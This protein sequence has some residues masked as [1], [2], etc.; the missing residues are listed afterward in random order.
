MREIRQGPGM[1]YIGDSYERAEAWI[2][3]TVEGHV[4]TITRTVVRNG[5]QHQGI[6]SRLVQHV[7]EYCREHEYRIVPVCSFAAAYFEKHPEDRD[8]LAGKTR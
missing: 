7:V 5:L 4:L 8:L 1:F 6:G 2:D 3:Y